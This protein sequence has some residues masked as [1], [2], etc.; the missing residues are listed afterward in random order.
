M[1]HCLHQI[2]GG[3]GFN[4]QATQSVVSSVLRVPSS[5]CRLLHMNHTS[6]APSH[7]HSTITPAQHHHTSTAPPHHHTITPAQH[8]HTSTAPS[9]Q[10]STITPAQH[11]HTST[12]EH[13]QPHKISNP[14]SCPWHSCPPPYTLNIHPSLL[15]PLNHHHTQINALLTPHQTP[16]HPP[17]NL[18]TPHTPQTLPLITPPSCP[19]NSSPHPLHSLRIVGSPPKASNCNAPILQNT[20]IA[21]TMLMGESTRVMTSRDCKDE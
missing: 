21:K 16:F 17:H 2:R 4:L 18:P 10:H 13:T 1:S 7:Q 8:Y 5:T 12:S 6:T 14:V 11:H 3:Y 20:T 19:P 15:H 9:H